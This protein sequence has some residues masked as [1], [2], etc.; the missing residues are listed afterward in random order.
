MLEQLKENIIDPASTCYEDTLKYT[1]KIHTNI[2]EGGKTDAT[3][4]Y[5]NMKDYFQTNNVNEY[6]V[7]DQDRISELLKKEK[8]KHKFER[9]C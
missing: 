1:N 7:I 9:V 2:L 5:F 8:L 3:L 6:Y 4:E